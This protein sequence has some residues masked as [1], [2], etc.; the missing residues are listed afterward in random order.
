M[1]VAHRSDDNLDVI[2]EPCQ[3]QDETVNREASQ[4]SRAECRD[5]RLVDA[6]A[7]GCRHLRESALLDHL[8][9]PIGELCFEQ[10]FLWVG[11]SDVREDVTA[12]DRYGNGFALVAVR[13][14]LLSS[15]FS[16]PLLMKRLCPAQP[17]FDQV[18]VVP[19]GCDATSGLFLKAVQ[20]IDCFG[21]AH[22]VD[23]PVGIAIEV[24]NELQDAGAVVAMSGF[25]SEGLPPNCAT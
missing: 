15:M 14:L 21:E 8:V 4:A 17:C 3:K 13:H 7:L 16:A 6:K 10:R 25:A 9:D 19:A 24:L 1:F 23:N 5:L 11:Y 12:S 2:A 18:D 20:D 22:R